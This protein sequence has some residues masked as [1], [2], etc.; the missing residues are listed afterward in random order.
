VED[1]NNR[2]YIKLVSVDNKKSPITAKVEI[3]VVKGGK[4]S[5]N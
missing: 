1:G 4:V 2:A 5:R 3:D